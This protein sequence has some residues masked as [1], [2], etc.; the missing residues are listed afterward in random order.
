MT[1]GIS[2]VIR[3]WLGWCPQECTP[4][5]QL[6][7][8][9]GDR[10]SNAPIQGE[11]IPK[12]TGLLQ[13]YRNQVLLLAVSFTFAAIPAIA[14]FHADDLTRPMMY[15]GVITGLGLFAFFGKWLWNSFGMLEKGM[16]IK[17]GP[18]AYIISFFIAGI[19]PRWFILLIAGILLI[20]S[21][22]GVLAFPA[23]VVGFAFVPWY[24]L[25][26]IVLWERR[27]GSTLMFDK[28]TRSF[29]AMRHPSASSVPVSQ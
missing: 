12:H 27:T 9:N 25:V 5:R 19:I 22:A 13:R 6:L 28:K 1:T 17:T 18:G 16:T 14:Y 11:G 21:F 20:I 8:L 23:F 7:A 29:R 15:A 3:G 4:P 10:V 24:V 2:E 26:L